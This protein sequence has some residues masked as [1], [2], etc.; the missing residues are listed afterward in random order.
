MGGQN[1]L[2]K[3]VVI[4]VYFAVVKETQANFFDIPIHRVRLGIESDHCVEVLVG[5]GRPA[6]SIFS[7]IV[8]CCATHPE[9]GLNFAP[10]WL[11]FISSVAEGGKR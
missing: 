6:M 8:I 3:I 4:K 1:R 7:H 9:T 10:E 2:G 5:D 11:V